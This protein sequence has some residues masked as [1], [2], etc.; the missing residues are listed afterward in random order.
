MCEMNLPGMLLLLASRHRLVLPNA[1][2]SAA[3]LAG[4]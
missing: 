2:L 1:K 3:P 4:V